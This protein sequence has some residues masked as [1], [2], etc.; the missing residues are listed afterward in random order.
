[1]FCQ[2]GKVLLMIIA[3]WKTQYNFKIP[4]GIYFLADA[5]YHNTDYVLCPYRGVRYLVYWVMVNRN[6]H[7]MV[8][9]VNKTQTQTNYVAVL[10]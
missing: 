2:V 10:Y 6:A 9:T 5:G 4:S 3:F 7:N 8:S 1:M